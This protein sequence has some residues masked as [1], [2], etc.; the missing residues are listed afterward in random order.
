MATSASG[1]LKFP[2]LQEASPPDTFQTAETPQMDSENLSNG[3][4][5]INEVFSHENSPVVPVEWI[6]ETFD[7]FRFCSTC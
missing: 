1:L 4:K 7:V 2:Q 6:I 5:V 3:C